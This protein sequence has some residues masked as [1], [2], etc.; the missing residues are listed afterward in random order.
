[1]E[2]ETLELETKIDNYEGD[3]Y[4]MQRAKEMRK[5]KRA[6]S[7]RKQNILIQRR[8]EVTERFEAGRL[9]KI[10]TQNYCTIMQACEATLKYKK[11]TVLIGYPG[12]GKTTAL[13]RFYESRR[14]DG[15]YGVVFFIVFKPSMKVK[16]IFKQII[17][18]SGD[19]YYESNLY[20][21]IELSA[22]KIKKLSFE[23]GSPA[24]VIIDEAGKLKEKDMEHIHEFRDLTKG[25][26]GIILSG[27]EFLQT[28]LDSLIKKGVRGMMEFKSRITD[29]V[30]LDRPTRKEIR[31]VCHEN[32]IEDE[33]FIEAACKTCSDF[34]RLEQMIFDYKV[35]SNS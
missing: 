6:D 30:S 22:H 12:A 24:L 10:E 23:K 9:K 26:C 3:D 13:E 25:D 11:M 19:N 18:Q 21:L 16:D 28:R 5:E 2:K 34:R 20:D 17:I 14:P 35:D 31:S 27:P 32:G 8:Q 29:W 33:S 4:H 1:M 15:T 7:L